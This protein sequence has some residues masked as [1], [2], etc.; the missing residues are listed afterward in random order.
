MQ[1]YK[2]LVSRM[3][4]PDNPLEG[5]Q[6]IGSINREFKKTLPK[7][8]DSERKKLCMKWQQYIHYSGKWNKYLNFVEKCI[9][10]TAE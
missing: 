3:S 2:E 1:N 8:A 9:N 7:K 5:A 6:I 4:N 10:E